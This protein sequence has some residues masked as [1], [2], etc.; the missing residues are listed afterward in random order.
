[1][2]RLPA[3]IVASL[4]TVLIATSCTQ[5]APSTATAPA[6]GAV[7]V[8]ITSHALE[9]RGLEHRILDYADALAR[10]S[11][12]TA[13][14]F[15]NA[16]GVSLSGP[17]KTPTDGTSAITSLGGGYGFTAE[18]MPGSNGTQAIINMGM[19]DGRGMMQMEDPGCIMDADAVSLA[20]EQRG[21]KRTITER[22]G[23]GWLREHHREAPGSESMFIDMRLYKTKAGALCVQRIALYG[24]TNEAG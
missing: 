7:S 1:M 9:V 20:L 3:N 17:G 15:G 10:S 11:D 23:S 13:D 6:P 2:G 12:I 16:L 8:A 4:G 21:Y 19:M 14:S 22:F 5:T 24:G 18:L